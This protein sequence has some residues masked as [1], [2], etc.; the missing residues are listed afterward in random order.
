[1]DFLIENGRILDPSAGSITQGAIAIE[2]GKIARPV[3]GKN[4]RQVIDA[5]GCI[6][7]PGLIDY[8]VHYFLNA[9]ENGV[10][11]DASSFC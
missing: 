10:N 9:T 4:Y 7:A 1:M 2:N 8:H 5:S 3:E 6:V 11:P